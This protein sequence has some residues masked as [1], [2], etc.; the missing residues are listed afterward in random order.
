M[1]H[2]IHGS[3][4]GRFFITY[5]VEKLTKED[6]EGVSFKYAPLKEA[7]EKYNPQKLNDGFNTLDNGEEIFYISNP[8][9][10]L[11]ACKNLFI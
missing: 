11:W 6:V 9:K 2:L 10:G 4:D 3:S 8:A 5:A 1:A 7:L